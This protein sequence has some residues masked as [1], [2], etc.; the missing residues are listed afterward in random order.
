MSYIIKQVSEECVLVPKAKSSGIS[1]KCPPH[2]PKKQTLNDT[3]GGVAE[4]VL[5]PAGRERK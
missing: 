3:D 4:Y 2:P 5:P 1:A